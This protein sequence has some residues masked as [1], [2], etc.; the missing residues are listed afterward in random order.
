MIRTSLVVF[1]QQAEIESQLPSHDYQSA[2]TG[3]LPAPT[4]LGA[5]VVVLPPALDPAVPVAVVPVVVVPVAVVPPGWV[6]VVVVVVPAVPV[7]LAGT[8][9]AG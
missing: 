5:V 4:A 6:V 3:L 2:G 1:I 8:E 9:V 7:W